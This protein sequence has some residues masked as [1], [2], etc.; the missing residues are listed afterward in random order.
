MIVHRIARG[1]IVFSAYIVSRLLVCA[2]QCSAIVVAAHHYPHQARD[3]R[4]FLEKN[5]FITKVI[6]VKRTIYSYSVLNISNDGA[7]QVFN[8]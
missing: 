7:S 1:I 2:R 3:V 8:S 5:E 6:E 4:T